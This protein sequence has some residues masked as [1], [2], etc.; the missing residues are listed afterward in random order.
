MNKIRKELDLP[1]ATI[2]WGWKYHHL[3]IPTEKKLKNEKYLPE[4]KMYISGFEESPYGIE[5]IRFDKNCDLPELV[6]TVPHLAFTVPDIHTALKGRNVI[7]E[8]NSPSEGVVVA[9]IEEN[10]APIE[11]MQESMEKIKKAGTKEIIYS[12]RVYLA[13]LDPDDAGALYG[14]RA[15]P[16]VYRY[17][18]WF[19]GNILDA[20]EFIL[21]HSVNSR[22]EVGSWKQFGI[23]MIESNELAGDCGYHRLSDTEAEIGYSISPGFQRRGLGLETVGS[24]TN[25]LF[26]KK[27]MEKI[28][29]STDPENIPS[30]KLL[31]NLGFTLKE[32]LKESV[33]IRGELKDDLVFELKKK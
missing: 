1:E 30:L 4:F 9:F 31:E 23:Y 15:L 24:L 12:E 10:G 2:E 26:N 32:H 27:G 13:D 7:V 8:P 29:A 17:Q 18:S 25:H 28:I 5:W 11:L 20:E 6:R 19:P 14:Y 22:G 21:K 3:G 33:E 16:E